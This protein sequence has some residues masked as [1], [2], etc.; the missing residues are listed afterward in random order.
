M[1]KWAV[2][3]MVAVGMW[4]AGFAW[5]QEKTGKDRRVRVFVS[6]KVQGVG[7]RAFVQ[8]EALALGVQGWV[9]NLEDGRVEAVAEGTK[10][11]VG[12]LLEKINKGPAAARVDKAEVTEETATGEFTKFDIK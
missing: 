5:A 9:K 8:K 7:F 6:G 3:A 4:M 10:E 2:V 12:A 11:K 1:T